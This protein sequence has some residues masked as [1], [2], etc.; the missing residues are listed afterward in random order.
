M[1]LARF[2]RGSEA[3]IGVAVG[4]RLIDLK[5]AYVALFASPAPPL[6]SDMRAFIEAGG[7]ALELAELLSRAATKEQIG[8]VMLKMGEVR[9]L[10]PV[11][12]EKVLCVAVNY[13][14]H[15]K[16]M[17]ISPPERP[18]FF[19]KLRNSLVGHMD[20]VLIPRGAEKPD[21]EV[22]LAVVIGRGGKYIEESKALDHVFGYTILNDVSLRDRQFR[23][24][25]QRLGAR[26]IAAK[27]F[28][29]A[30]PLG[31]V[32][33]TKDEIGEP[34]S[35]RLELYVNGELRQLGS[36]GDMI[37]R[38]P[39]L[40]AEASEG[41]T[42]RAGDVIS[43]GTPAGVGAA[44]GKFLRHGDVMEARIERIGSLVNP[45]V[46]EAPPT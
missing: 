43:T 33:V 26:W 31:P 46:Y 36:S 44:S 30:A 25:E 3:R 12:P 41:L 15:A 35:L 24:G 19:A 2:L 14:S 23:P 27:S 22:E 42:L 21:H 20:P 17:N 37:F 34:H 28:D 11:E 16:E 10:P 7:P 40:I 18:Y 38:I 29:T 1:K 5:E 9:I 8:S 4:D 45:V 39:A 32:I 13:Y 6:L